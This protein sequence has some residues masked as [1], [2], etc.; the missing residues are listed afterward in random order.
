M[1]HHDR[2]AH[3]ARR[4]RV[5]GREI[6]RRSIWVEWG[7]IVAVLVGALGLAAAG[8]SSVLQYQATR[9][10]LEQSEIARKREQKEQA[11][12]IDTSLI[13]PDRKETVLV[14]T[15]YSRRSVSRYGANIGG[16]LVVLP[17]VP[18]CTQAEVQIY[19]LEGLS[20]DVRDLDSE[21][22]AHLFFDWE[23]R[24]WR[25]NPVHGLE[26]TTHDQYFEYITGL[27]GNLKLADK[28]ESL[29]KRSRVPDC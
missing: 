24:A 2:L 12:L 29:T 10:Q 6:M 28:V 5:T 17:S 20:I 8:W 3:I 23:G 22:Y 1:P 27:A 18:P 16:T 4:R 7:Q 11:S 9:D 25:F 13:S 21:F 26:S 15:N 19:K 14:V